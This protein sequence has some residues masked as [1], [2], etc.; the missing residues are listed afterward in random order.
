[1]TLFAFLKAEWSAA[2][3][4]P[5]RLRRPVNR[6]SAPA[7]DCTHYRTAVVELRRLPI[8]RPCTRSHAI[9]CLS[10]TAR[11]SPYSREH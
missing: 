10:Y 7:R 11:I 4:A 8:T 5:P 3:A 1:M 9:G 2:T 6:P